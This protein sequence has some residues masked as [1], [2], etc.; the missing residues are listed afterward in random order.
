MI[1]SDDVWK[2]EEYAEW[3]RLAHSRELEK[4]IGHWIC[5]VE[6]GVTKWTWIKPQ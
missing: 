2:S 5:V 6:D 1:S 3:L 4:D